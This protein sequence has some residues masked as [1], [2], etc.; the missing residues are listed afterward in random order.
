MSLEIRLHFWRRRGRYAGQ[1]GLQVVT[2]PLNRELIWST[3]TQRILD[4]PEQ[5]A[6]PVP[7]SFSLFTRTGERTAGPLT[8]ALAS[9]AERAG[10]VPLTPSQCRLFDIMLPEGEVRPSPAEA[11]S[12]LVQAALLKLPY[13]TRGEE[14]DIIG[15]PPFDIGAPEREFFEALLTAAEAHTS[16]V[17]DSESERETSSSQEGVFFDFIGFFDFGAFHR[18]EWSDMSLLNVV[19]G[20]NDT[21]KSHLL[22][23]MYAVARSVQEY[24]ARIEADQPSWSKVLAEKLVWTFEPQDGRLGRLVR[25]AGVERAGLSVLAT[26]RNEEYT[27]SFGP[28]AGGEPQDFGDITSNIRPQPGIQAL[29]IPPKEVLTALHAIA[30][31]RER[32]KMFGFDN[33]YYDLVVAL[34][35]Q[36]VQV[37]LPE[38]FQRVLADL[39]GLLGGRIE[40]EQN[41]FVFLRDGEKYGMSQTAEGFKKI[42]ILTRLILNGELR[43]NSI[44]FLDE[45]EANLHPRAARALV[46]ML[47]ELSRAG[48]QIFVATHSYFVLKQFEILARSQKQSVKLCSLDRGKDGVRASFFDLRE[49]MP[50]NAIV[51]EAIRQYDE[52]VEVTER[53]EG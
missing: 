23:M 39:E 24:T 51:A 30:A 32:L 20:A 11:F 6:C 35:G 10:L 34:R 9:A 19:V 4:T 40:E 22:K 42:G 53:E 26:L 13:V 16:E 1:L 17:K 15:S 28:E 50:D 27:F 18:F 41:R 43:R 14:S 5:G 7:A 25:R 52:D 36:P 2:V 21:G 45:P 33:T 37:A 8:A 38:P 29:F 44:L 48:V 31:V 47:Y 49:G 12:S 46:R 3:L